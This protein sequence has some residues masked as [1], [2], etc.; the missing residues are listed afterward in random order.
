MLDRARRDT[1]ICARLAHFDNA[2]MSLTPQ[3]VLNTVFAHLSREQRMGGYAAEA[4]RAERLDAG[5]AS[6]ARLVGGKPHEIAFMLN[7]SRA[8]ELA[9]ASLR[10]G[11]GDRVIAH[12]TEYVANRLSLNL[13]RRDGVEVD[14]VG[15]DAAGN[16]D[17]DAV[18]KAVTPHTRAIC[19]THVPS[20]HGR[21]NP[22]AQIGAVAREA[23][24]PFFLDACQSAGQIHLDVE[25]IGCDVLT[26][27]GRKF[28]RGPRGTGFL[29]V[30]ES[31]LP[32]LEPRFPDFRSARYDGP[33]GVAFVGTARKF[34]TY[35]HPVAAKLGFIRAV[36]Y[37]LEL[38]M[39]AIEAR[40]RH[41]SAILRSALRDAGMTVLPDQTSGIVVFDHPEM[42]PET[43]RA[44]LASRRINVS[45]ST[46][47]FDTPARAVRASVHYYNTEEEIDVIV[48]ALGDIH[49]RESRS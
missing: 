47:D 16:M 48:A 24:V 40:V 29:W 21:V 22:V 3:P 49:D 5:Y 2:G 31:L 9:L 33:D 43:V 30:R 42:E 45:V 1:P 27:T 12:H 17:S 25:A 37:A 20:T 26:A 41:L 35:E 10:L 23:G 34:E 15:S 19:A 32:K 36:D 46:R 38:G 44:A 28:L 6:L 18:R 4:D 11:P 7:A 8:W 13:L 14:L 39:P